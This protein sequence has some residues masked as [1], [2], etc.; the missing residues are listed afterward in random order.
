MEQNQETKSKCNWCK[1][2]IDLESDPIIKVDGTG[3]CRK[4]WESGGQYTKPKVR[5]IYDL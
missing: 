3:V 1:G 4:C 5:A 2:K